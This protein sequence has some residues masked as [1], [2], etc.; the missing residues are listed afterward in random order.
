MQYV[1]LSVTTSNLFGADDGDPEAEGEMEA[2]KKKIDMLEQKVTDLSKVTSNLKRTDTNMLSIG[3][4][5]YDLPK[6]PRTDRN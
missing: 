6:S 5:P 4:I 3:D 2:I 1:L